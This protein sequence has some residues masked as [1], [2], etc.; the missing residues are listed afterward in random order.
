MSTAPAAC[1]A[2][3]AERHAAAPRHEEAQDV[4]AVVRD[5]PVP[6]PRDGKPRLPRDSLPHERAAHRPHNNR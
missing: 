2:A 5:N 1:K 3:V 4:E 6:R